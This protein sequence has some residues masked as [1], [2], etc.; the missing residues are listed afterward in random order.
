MTLSHW[1]AITESRNFKA[2]F[3]QPEFSLFSI[4][5]KIQIAQGF[6]QIMMFTLEKAIVDGFD[7]FDVESGV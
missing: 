7:D 6:I 3:D 4:L 2:N 5:I 1:I